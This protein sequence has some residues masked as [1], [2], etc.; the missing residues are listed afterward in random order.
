MAR[1]GMTAERLVLAA[2]ELADEVGFENVT[3]SA[4]ARRFG[5]RDAS[6][7]S[8]IRNAQELRE[9][10]SRLALTEL[11]DQA[12]NALAGRSGRDA[13]VAFANAYRDYARRHPGRYA[14][15]QLPVS[16][17]TADAARRHSELTRAILRGYELPEAEHV[18]AVRLLHSTFHGY[19]SLERAGGFDHSG[20]VAA[21]WRRVLD[22]LDATLAHWPAP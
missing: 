7:Y 8:H 22:V 2:A 18:H 5:I 13:L 9:Q 19:V 17:A 6:F 10:V 16:P 1:V 4:L 12:A 11:A 21:S 15:G 3:V 20:D 14:A